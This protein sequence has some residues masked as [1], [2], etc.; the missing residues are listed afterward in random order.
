MTTAT[1]KRPGRSNG[2]AYKS[3]RVLLREMIRRI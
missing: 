1:K 3:A 2:L